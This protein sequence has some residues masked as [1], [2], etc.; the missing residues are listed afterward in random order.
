MCVCVCVCACVCVRVHAY[1]R[2]IALPSSHFHHLPSHLNTNVQTSA[3]TCTMHHAPCTMHHALAPKST[4]CNGT[5]NHLPESVSFHSVR[6]QL[7]H[8]IYTHIGSLTHTHTHGH[9]HTY[10]HAH[11]HTCTHTHTRI[12]T[13]TYTHI[14]THTHTPPPTH[15]Q[16]HTLTHIHTH[17]LYASVR[18]HNGTPLCMLTDSAE[19]FIHVPTSCPQP[20]VYVCVR[21]YACVRV[22]VC[23]YVCVCV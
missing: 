3:C 22:R 15:T 23:V 18:H 14:C 1:V 19:G 13:H 5:Q 21:V 11:A 4:V 10:T 9:T 7:H 6:A 16:P 2:S 20:P 8:T 12:H 17:L